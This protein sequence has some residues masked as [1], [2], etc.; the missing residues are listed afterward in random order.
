MEAR[1]TE[2]SEKENNMVE[3]T[4]DLSK[5]EED[6]AAREAKLDEIEQ[7]IRLLQSDA[8]QQAGEEQRVKTTG[9]TD[10]GAG[11]LHC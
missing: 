8:E 4:A 9:I 11:R 1:E 6:I 2:L 7:G 10:G 5:R 3:R